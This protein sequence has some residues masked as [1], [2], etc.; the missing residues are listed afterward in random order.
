M[1]KFSILLLLLINF[2]VKSQSSDSTHFSKFEVGFIFS[3]DYSYRVLKTDA[4]HSWMKY[5]YDTLEVS[6]FSFTAGASI[7]LRLTK[8]LSLSTGILFADKGEKTKRYA[9]RNAINYTNHFYYLDIPLKVNYY[10]RDKKYYF[11]K[12]R[13]LKLFLSAGNSVNIFLNSRSITRTVNTG[14]KESLAISPEISRINIS[15]LAGFGLEY[16]LTQK[17]LFRLESNYRRSITPVA[18]TSLKKYFYSFGLN[19]GLSC[20][21]STSQ[22]SYASSM[23]Q[24]VLKH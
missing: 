23:K 24:V 10:L 22:K 6:R 1:R 11:S 8:K 5:T 14:D 15:L 19:I 20:K 4:S 21:I 3:P 2:S 16:P 18:N 7:L 9:T 17:W 13:K 12:P